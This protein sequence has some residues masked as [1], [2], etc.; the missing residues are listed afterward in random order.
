MKSIYTEYAISWC[1]AACLLYYLLLGNTSLHTGRLCT[2]TECNFFTISDV[3]LI[4]DEEIE[5]VE[6]EKGVIDKYYT[7][8]GVFKVYANGS[9][10]QKVMLHRKDGE[11]IIWE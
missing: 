11:L 6:S 2:D 4:D 1:I 7:Q 3:I 10:I 8:E 9:N 5:I